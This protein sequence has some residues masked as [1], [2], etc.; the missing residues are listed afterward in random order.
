MNFLNDPMSMWVRVFFAA[1]GSRL[2][3]AWRDKDRG[4]SAVELAVIAAALVVIAMII[5]VA[6]NAFVTKQSDN[7]SKTSTTP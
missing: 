7:L 3:E 5:V 6:I 4:A 2:R 1:H